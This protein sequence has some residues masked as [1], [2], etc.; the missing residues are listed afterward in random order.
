MAD[1]QPTPS[2]PTNVQQAPQTPNQQSDFFGGGEDAFKNWTVVSPNTETSI[3]EEP[4]REPT[5][6]EEKVETL[7]GWNVET[8]SHEIANGGEVKIE[9]IPEPIVEPIPEAVIEP[10]ETM[11][12]P[13]SEVEEE[14]EPIAEPVTVQ[15]K[16]PVVQS[17]QISDLCKKFM[18]LEQ[19]CKQ[20][21]EWKKTNEGF[22]LVWADNDTLHVLYTFMLGDPDFP[23]V[24]VTKTETDKTDD[25]ETTHELNFYLNEDGTSLNVNLD[26]ELLFEEAVDLVD[27]VNKKMQVMDKLNKFIFLVS[28][29]SKKIEKE[30]KVKQAEQEEK[31]KLQDVFRNF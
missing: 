6:P 21:E 4:V 24:V 16:E 2:I 30:I 29:E 22:S 31:R 9:P 18:E 7:K 27:D 12:E 26:E 19:L 17:T 15:E 20:I 14:V 25:E 13:I 23:M 5:I 8:S 10:I 11:P 28:E 3:P 1:T